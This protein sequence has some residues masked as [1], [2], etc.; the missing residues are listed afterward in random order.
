MKL[1]IGDKV[2]VNK[3][4]LNRNGEI[5]IVIERWEDTHFRVQFKDKLC[6]WFT[7]KNEKFGYVRELTFKEIIKE[8]IKPGG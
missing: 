2:K 8:S 4:G 1:K 3:R 5:G 6:V 7:V